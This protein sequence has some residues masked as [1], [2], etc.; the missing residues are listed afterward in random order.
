MA[1]AIDLTG[2]VFGRLTAIEPTEERRDG[3]I[4][5]K[6]ACSCGS[7]VFVISRNLQRGVTRSCGCLRRETTRI[8]GLSGGAVCPVSPA[9]LQE[10]YKDGHSIDELAIMSGCAWETAKRWLLD[11]NVELRCPSDVM[12]VT[13]RRRK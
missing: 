12:R 1:K 3:K 13:L 5:W 8:I 10:M 9:K 4:V 6:C 2:Q 7:F 11:Q